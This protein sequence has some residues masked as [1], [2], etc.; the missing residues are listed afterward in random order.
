MSSM[1]YDIVQALVAANVG[2]TDAKVVR[3]EYAS[4]TAL[5]TALSLPTNLALVPF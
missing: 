1:N 2:S 3:G 4:W 5:L